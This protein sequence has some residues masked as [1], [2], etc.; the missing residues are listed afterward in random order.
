MLNI[1]IPKYL[2]RANAPIT[3][4][5][6]DFWGILKSKVYAKNWSAK[7]KPELKRKIRI[8]LK[9]MDVSLVLLL[10]SKKDWILYIEKA[11]IPYNLIKF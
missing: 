7:S 8:F 3:R 6:E 1:K 5:I 4:T 11:M 9:E 10:V 2:N